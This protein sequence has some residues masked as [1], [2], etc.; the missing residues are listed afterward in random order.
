MSLRRYPLARLISDYL[1]AGAGVALAIA[2]PIAASGGPIVSAVF[3]AIGGLALGFGLRTAAR[4]LTRVAVTDD[5]IA[6]TS[7]RTRRI[8]WR[9]ISGVRLR[10]FPT[11]WRRESGWLVLSLR[12]DGTR[13]RLDSDLEGF[14]D[15]VELAI[16]AAAANGVTLD[17]AGE[18]NLARLGLLP[19][20]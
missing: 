3:A 19:R 13:L 5:A 17:R 9:A 10:H 8:A 4:Q 7:W 14:T 2:L 18:L 16:E 11:G 12:D 6:L 20:R 15:V 1:R